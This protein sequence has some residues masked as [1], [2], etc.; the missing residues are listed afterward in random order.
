MKVE[1]QNISQDPTEP[2]RRFFS[3]SRHFEFLIWYQ[4]PEFKQVVG[5]QISYKPSP[6]NTSEEYFLTL[7]PNAKEMKY[8]TL[9]D[10]DRG[11]AAT[12]VIGYANKSP[13]TELLDKIRKAMLELPSDIQDSLKR[14]F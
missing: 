1:E 5:F 10:S 2:A 11:I 13:S 9:T 7:K 4:G 14:H 12:K 8:G 3:D 6:L